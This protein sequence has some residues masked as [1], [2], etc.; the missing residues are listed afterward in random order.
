MCRDGRNKEDYLKSDGK[1]SIGA[2]YPVGHVSMVAMVDGRRVPVTPETPGASGY[3]GQG[4]IMC[5][6]DLGQFNS[7]FDLRDMQCSSR[8]T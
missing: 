4:C 1:S 7:M 8:L 3:V 2:V 6:S 5:M